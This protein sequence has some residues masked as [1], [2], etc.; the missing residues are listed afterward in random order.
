MPIY[1]CTP[2]KTSQDPHAYLS[3]Y[4]GQNQ[5]GSSCLFITLPRTKPVRILMPIY[6]STPDKTSQDPHAYSSLYPGQNQSGSSCLFITLSL[7][8]TSQDPHAYLSLYP[9]KISQMKPR[10]LLLEEESKCFFQGS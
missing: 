4:P 9:G 10:L 3:L 6:H 1:H 2:D 7:D 8:K 5:S